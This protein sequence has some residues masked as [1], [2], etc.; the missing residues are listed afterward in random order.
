MKNTVLV[1]VFASL[2]VAAG[3]LGLAPLIAEG[4]KVLM[5]ILGAGTLLCAVAGGIRVSDRRPIPQ[6]A[7]RGRGPGA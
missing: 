7:T 3:S 5:V 2:V 1:A 4:F 6:L